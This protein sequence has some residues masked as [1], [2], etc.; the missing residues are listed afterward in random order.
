LAA[1][2]HSFFQ[3]FAAMLKWLPIPLCLFALLSGFAFAQ[4]IGDDKG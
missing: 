2:E 3:E 1:A 4:N